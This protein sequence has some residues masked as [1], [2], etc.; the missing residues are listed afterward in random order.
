MADDKNKNLEDA[1]KAMATDFPDIQFIGFEYQGAFDYAPQDISEAD[2]GKFWQ[3]V[4]IKA[5]EA[6][7]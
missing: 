4:L 6:R 2:F 7:V 1:Q 3:G 5:K